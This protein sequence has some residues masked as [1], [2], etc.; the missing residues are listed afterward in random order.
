[1]K[2]VNT[3]NTKIESRTFDEHPRQS[4]VL[5]IGRVPA[6]SRIAPLISCEKHDVDGGFLEIFFNSQYIDSVTDN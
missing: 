1:L 4:V 2:K 3:P 5:Y 6:G